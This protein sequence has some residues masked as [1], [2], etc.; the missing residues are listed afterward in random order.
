M[1]PEE[2]ANQKWFDLKQKQ[3]SEDLGLLIFEEKA[4]H[5]CLLAKLLWE[6]QGPRDFSDLQNVFS[7]V[8]SECS[9]MQFN[10]MTAMEA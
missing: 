2:F 8:V 3:S 6:Y 10:C 7:T 9:T 5:L 1:T 4:T